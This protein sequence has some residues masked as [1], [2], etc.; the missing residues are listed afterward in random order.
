MK[1]PS[2]AYFVFRLNWLA[3]LL[4]WLLLGS[5]QAAVPAVIHINGAEF[6][7]S[8]SAT[9]PMASAGWTPIALP[10]HHLKPT[11]RE[12][13]GYWYKAGF[14]TD[15]ATQPQWVLFEQIISGGEVYVNGV[16]IGEIPSSNEQLQ[17]RW[18]LPQ[19]WMIP[20]AVLHVGQNE[21]EVKFAIRDPFTSFGAITI[22]PEKI[23][24]GMFDQLI[25]WEDTTA[26]ISAALCLIAGILI[27]IIWVRRPQETIYGLFGLCV[28]FWGV[29]TYLL[30]TPVIST[31]ILLWWR[32]GYYFA[33]AG[34]VVFISLFMLSFCQRPQPWY[35]RFLIS[36]WLI[37]SG[38]FMVFGMSSRHFIE[39]YWLTG[40]VPLNLYAITHLMVYAARQRTHNALAMGL[41]VMFALGLTV[42]D[43][44][45]Q[46]N[47]VSWPEIYLM[48]LGIPAFLL[49]MIGIL[50]DRFLDSLALVENINEQLEL[51]VNKKESQLRQSYVQLS[52]L[53][54]AHAATEERERIIQ[55]MHDG[56]GSQLLTTL[57]LAQSSELPQQTMV[58][59]LQECLDDMRLV[60]DSTSPANR[61]LLPVLGNFR[62]RMESRFRALG[63]GFEWRNQAIPEALELEPDV[64]LQVLRIVQE[65]LANTL[66]HAQAKNVLV[67]LRF[68][69]QSLCIRI[70][71]D[72][73]GF[74]E[75]TKPKGRGVNN[76]R[77]RAQKIGAVIQFKQLLPGTEVC[78]DLAL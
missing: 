52:K 7:I 31:D 51:R 30:R 41:A 2:W 37:G 14:I 74:E 11:T 8:D 9:L 48:H 5:V 24:R 77:L 64:G 71:D 33:T 63:I 6:I 60:I 15:Q 21:I 43:L 68:C 28:V 69:P 50:L 61:D 54:R 13:V 18:Y 44:A 47:W 45:V 53:E 49:V 62:F 20:P 10:H 76:M 55:D 75:A 56:V 65:A 72:G 29:R 26:D 17:V 73:I 59:L 38:V 67:E 78:L 46:E 66:K 22:G 57:M 1:P 58:T 4:L 23:Q 34:F 12:L 40:F 25:F 36:Y 19:L 35:S 16:M 39:A 32:L 27:L 42:H 70:V 3:G